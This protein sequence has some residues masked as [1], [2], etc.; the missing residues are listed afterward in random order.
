M[1]KFVIYVQ[2]K[3]QSL[4]VVIQQRFLKKLGAEL[5][6]ASPDTPEHNGVAERFNQTIQ[7]KVRAYIYDAKIPESLWDLAVNSAVYSYN[8]TPHKSNDMITPLQRFAPHHNFNINQI[9]RFGCIAYIKVQRKIG[10]KFRFEGRRVVLVGYTPTGYQFLKPEE[11]KYYESRDVRFNEKLVYGDKYG[12][13]AIKDFP[14]DNVELNKEKW[15]VE[16]E[17]DENKPQEI[18]GSEGQSLKP[19]G[20]IKR[21][22]GRPKKNEQKGSEINSDK[23]IEMQ[24]N[25]INDCSF[26]NIPVDDK[27]KS[28]LFSC[29]VNIE[30]E[31]NQA[32]DEIFHALLADINSDPINYKEAIES[33]D[34]VFW[35]EA[36]NDELKSMTKNEVWKIVDRPAM[37]RDG[38]KANIIDSKWVFKRKIE[39]NGNMKYK[40][41]LVIRGFK[42]RNFYELRECSSITTS[43]GKIGN[44]NYK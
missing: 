1:L 2:I 28:V 14:L 26:I 6:L 13:D 40:A 36:I 21:K 41:R 16:F 17:L 30:T 31:A 10:P 5:Q 29:F 20:E 8:R 39:M 19:E 7:K 33:K 44:C 35:Q 11:G 32:E 38:R 3:E 22:R 24:T 27:I 34:K 25:Y 12:R 15:F 18:S 23:N 42:D 43:F 37:M 4:Q 9:K